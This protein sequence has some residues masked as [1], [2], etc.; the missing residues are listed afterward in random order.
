MYKAIKPLFSLQ[1]LSVKA[2]GFWVVPIV[3][4]FIQY[5]GQILLHYHYV[6]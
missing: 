6:S 2:L 3:C 1:T 4:L 5:L